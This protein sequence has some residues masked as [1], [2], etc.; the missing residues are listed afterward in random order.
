MEGT[1]GEIRMFAGNYAPEKWMI[2]A[3][4]T[5]NISQQ[6][7]LFSILSNTFGGDG[8]TNFK[9]PDL[10][11][12]SPL[13]VIA[14]GL[15]YLGRYFGDEE[16]KLEISEIYPHTHTPTLTQVSYSGTAVQRCFKGMGAGNT[17]PENRYFGPAPSGA[18]VYYNSFNADMGEVDVTITKSG[19]Y[20]V[21]VESAG[22]GQALPL[23][24]P[25]LCVSFIICVEGNYPTPK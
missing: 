24:Q 23:C 20:S 3:G 17:D 2:C 9:L 15:A 22:G 5:L 18:P 13:G 16:R 1:I 10:R 14:N 6:G 25:S 21:Q 12:R 7:V 11:G 4:Q 8:R 19:D